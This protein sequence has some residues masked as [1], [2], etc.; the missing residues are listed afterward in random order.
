VHPASTTPAG[1]QDHA[2][3]REGEAQQEH[4]EQE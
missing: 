1:Y 2:A 4:G 3:D